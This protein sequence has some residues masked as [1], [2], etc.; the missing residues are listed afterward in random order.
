[1]TNKLKRIHSDFDLIK[2]LKISLFSSSCNYGA[3]HMSGF[4]NSFHELIFKN[5]APLLASKLEGGNQNLLTPR[6]S[7]GI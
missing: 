3:K 1:M 4:A 7:F 6:G 2:H 5:F